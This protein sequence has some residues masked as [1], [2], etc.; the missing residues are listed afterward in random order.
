VLFPITTSKGKITNFSLSTCLYFQGQ[1]ARRHVSSCISKCVIQH[2]YSGVAPQ[3]VLCNVPR[4]VM[5]RRPMQSPFHILFNAAADVAKILHSALLFS[6]FSSTLYDSTCYALIQRFVSCLH[7]HLQPRHFY[8]MLHI[9][10][11][12]ASLIYMDITY[13]EDIGGM[14]KWVMG[15]LLH[16]SQC[17]QVI[18]HP[19]QP[20]CHL[21]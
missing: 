13:S 6:N 10:F 7:I 5:S 17:H 14:V 9:N 8:T 20:A 1:V 15:Y 2:P 21:I 12:V 19:L 11:V 18:H 4:Q 16:N 3:N